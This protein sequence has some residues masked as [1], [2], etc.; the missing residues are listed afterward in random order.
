M[1]PINI[2]N[3]AFLIGYTSFELFGPIIGLYVTYGIQKA[4]NKL[5]D[6]NIICI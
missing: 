6:I 5:T 2:Q 1:Q 4:I 3:G